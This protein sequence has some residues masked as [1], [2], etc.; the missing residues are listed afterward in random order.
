MEAHL[1]AIPSPTRLWWSA[2][3]KWQA[4]TVGI[5]L[6]VFF[7][8]LGITGDK[9]IAAITVVTTAIAAAAFVAV[10]IPAFATAVIATF[11]AVA[12]VATVFAF[13]AFAGVAFVTAFTEKAPGVGRKAIWFS[14]M[15]EFLLVL[16]PML[17][18]L[19]G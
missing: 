15:G 2:L 6:V 8:T 19:R 16:L 4:L 9:P 12:A 7:V 1:A 13:A 17:W 14:Y 11:V 3:G 10:F 5:T 18:V